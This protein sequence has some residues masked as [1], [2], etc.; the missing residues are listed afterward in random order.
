MGCGGSKAV[1]TRAS[2]NPTSRA[3]ELAPTGGGSILLSRQAHP[4]E[5]ALLTAVDTSFVV[6][7]GG[8]HIIGR[9]DAGA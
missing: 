3:Q 6:S 9:K 5:D 2:D 7:K 1:A 4:N 8:S